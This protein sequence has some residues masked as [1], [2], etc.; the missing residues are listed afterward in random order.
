[1]K[2]I[3]EI[4]GAGSR[5][6]M[7]LGW[8]GREEGY[9]SSAAR[10][11]TALVLLSEK[12]GMRWYRDTEDLMSR[13]AT[14][15]VVPTT[16]DALAGLLEESRNLDWGETATSFTAFLST[17]PADNDLPAAARIHITCGSPLDRWNKIHLALDDAFPLG[18]VS[19][20][21]VMFAEFVRIWQPDYARLSNSEVNA[22]LPLTRASYISWTS[23]KAYTEPESEKEAAFAF[24][25]G[26]LR[27]AREWT[28]DGIV[29]LNQAL[30]EAG[31]PQLSVRPKKQ[32]TPQFPDELPEGLE[33]LDHEVELAP[34]GA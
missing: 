19:D 23:A 32:D 12:T 33:S 7:S 26:T 1:M 8:S 20:A 27:V 2:T 17:G 3:R 30:T 16:P 15:V 28:V 6:T 4:F 31:A 10:L 22:T 24:G 14:F 11:S 5:A 25:D 34:Q 18:S 13:K 9:E 29:G 21:A